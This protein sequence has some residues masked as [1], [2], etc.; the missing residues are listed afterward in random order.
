MD[1]HIHTLKGY[2]DKGQTWKAIADAIAQTANKNGIKATT[3]SL[4]Q[5]EADEVFPHGSILFG[6]NARSEPGRAAKLFDYKATKDSL[7]QEIPITFER[8]LKASKL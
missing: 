3:K 8:E 1:R 7:E 5:A 2:T 6:T 4:N